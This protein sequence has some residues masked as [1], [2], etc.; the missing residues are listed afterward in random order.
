MIRCRGGGGVPANGRH[1]RVHSCSWLSWSG[2]HDDGAR[3]ADNRAWD[4]AEEDCGGVAQIRAG[5]GNRSAACRGSRVRI[6][7]ADGRRARCCSS[8]LV[9]PDIGCR[10]RDRVAAL[11]QVERN[12]RPNQVR[13]RGGA[14]IAADHGQRGATYTRHEHLLAIDLDDNGHTRRAGNVG[15]VGQRDGVARGGNG[16]ANRRDSATMPNRGTAS[17]QRHG[18][19]GSAVG[20]QRV[21]GR[22][23]SHL[24][25]VAAVGEARHAGGDVNEV[26]DADG[27]DCPVDGRAGG[28]RVVAGHQGGAHL[29]RAAVVDTATVF[30]VTRGSVPTCISAESVITQRH[31]AHVVDAAAVRVKPI[32][33]DCR[34]ADRRSAAV[35]DATAVGK[36]KVARDCG[37]VDVQCAGVVDAAAVMIGRVAGGTV[38]G[39]A[40]IGQRQ[41]AGVFNAAAASNKAVLDGQARD[42]GR[43]S[44]AD[45]KNLMPIGAADRQ[46]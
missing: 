17:W 37:S 24:I 28:G 46:A 5:D 16:C 21:G 13:G 2:G 31:C 7:I 14:V 35:V 26:V 4:G 41:R 20:C 3:V 9:G 19:R 45:G 10:G 18:V 11:V 36:R 43:H 8:R 12:I 32:S 27:G 33:G 23:D 39:D 38:A 15:I 30:A 1:G 34:V 29:E 44:R 22:R 6:D 25:A 40:V 42:A